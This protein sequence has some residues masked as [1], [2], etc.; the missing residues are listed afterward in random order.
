MDI[1]K[2]KKANLMVLD[3]GTATDIPPHI[4]FGRGAHYNPTLRQF[5]NMKKKGYELAPY[6]LI[7]TE[8]T[9]YDVLQEIEYADDHH[10]IESLNIS[11]YMKPVS[12]RDKVRNILEEQDKPDVELIKASDDSFSTIFGRISD[13]SPGSGHIVIDSLQSMEHL[14]PNNRHIRLARMN[15]KTSMVNEFLKHTAKTKYGVTLD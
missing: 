13:Y 1:F 6:M 9:M 14:G 8:N 4:R 5:M 12:V 11:D 10:T 3:E 2:K 15:G 7:N